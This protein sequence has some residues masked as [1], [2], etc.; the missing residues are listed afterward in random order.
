MCC[1]LS[2]L[3]ALQQTAIVS[4]VNNLI[5]MHQVIR[6]GPFVYACMDEVYTSAVAT[7]V[8]D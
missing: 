2:D 7:P 6:A 4:Q 8:L 1:M 5:D 3:T